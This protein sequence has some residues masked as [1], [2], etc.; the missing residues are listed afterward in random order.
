[1]AGFAYNS[2]VG[3]V[4]VTSERAMFPKA[5]FNVVDIYVGPVEHLSTRP[6]FVKSFLFPKQVFR[7]RP[8][9]VGTKQ[10]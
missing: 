10:S 7:L 4:V 5:R 3:L 9:M 1:M 8:T 2:Q 6:A